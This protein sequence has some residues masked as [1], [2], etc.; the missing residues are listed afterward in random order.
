M[1]PRPWRCQTVGANASGGFHLYL[2]D[3]NGRKIAALWGGADE[4]AANGE[5]ICDLINERFPNG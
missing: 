1:A 2:V 4:K 5:A 3:A